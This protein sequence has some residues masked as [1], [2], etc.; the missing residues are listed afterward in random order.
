MLRETHAGVDGS[1][2]IVQFNPFGSI[3]AGKSTFIFDHLFACTPWRSVTN[4]GGSTSNKYNQQKTG[5]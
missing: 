5:L 4:D 2:L 1:K 3:I